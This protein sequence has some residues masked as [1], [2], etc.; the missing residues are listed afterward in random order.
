[1]YKGRL[2]DG[3]VVAVK[4]L[5]DAGASGEAQFKTEVEIIS[6]AVHRNLLRLVGFCASGGEQLLVYPYMPN[7]SVLSRLRGTFILINLL[8]TNYIFVILQG[9]KNSFIS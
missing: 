3:S 8:F 2:S 1:M 9:F 5:K 7:G 6:L 4:R